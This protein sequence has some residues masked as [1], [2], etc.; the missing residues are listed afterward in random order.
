MGAAVCSAGGH[1]HHPATITARRSS[2]YELNAMDSV[3]QISHGVTGLADLAALFRAGRNELV[4]RRPQETGQ[5]V[6]VKEVFLL[7]LKACLRLFAC[8]ELHQVRFHMEVK[9]K[10]NQEVTA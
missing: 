10:G 7:T 8:S 9:G 2:L 1:H 6:A 4:D 5:L 3:C